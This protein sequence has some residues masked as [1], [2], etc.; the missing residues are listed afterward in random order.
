[1][2]T[3]QNM[4]LLKTWIYKKHVRKIWNI[5]L[6]EW[7]DHALS[8]KYS[9]IIFFLNSNCNESSQNSQNSQNSTTVQNLWKKQFAVKKKKKIHAPLNPRC[10]NRANKTPMFSYMVHEFCRHYF[11]LL[12]FFFINQVMWAK[13]KTIISF[14]YFIFSYLNLTFCLAPLYHVYCYKLYCY[15]INLADN[16]NQLA[17]ICS[18]ST[19]ETLEKGVKYIQRFR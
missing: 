2:K 7:L 9:Q 18:K 5:T 8:D 12:I 16:C 4:L 1:M 15:E 3:E 13:Q 11:P 10:F 6:Q 14:Y 17:F 19:I